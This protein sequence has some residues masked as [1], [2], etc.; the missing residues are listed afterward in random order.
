ML[1]LVA[2]VEGESEHPLG[3]ALFLAAMDRGI[4]A[5]TPTNLRVLVGEGVVPTQ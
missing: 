5:R 4:A 2:S 3:R 1:E